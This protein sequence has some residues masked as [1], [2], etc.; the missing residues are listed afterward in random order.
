MELDAFVLNVK[1]ERA[2]Q[3]IEYNEAEKCAV[4]DGPLPADRFAICPICAPEPV[5]IDDAA[6]YRETAREEALLEDQRGIELTERIVRL[7]R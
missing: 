1:Q 2:G 5:Y 6:A 3:M 4:C 7:R